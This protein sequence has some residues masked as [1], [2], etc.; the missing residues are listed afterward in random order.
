MVKRVARGVPEDKVS[1]LR[2]SY[3]STWSQFVIEI[4]KL[5]GM[6]YWRYVTSATLGGWR[7]NRFY[8]KYSV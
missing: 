8:R 2:R 3:E 4:T 7:L 6:R 1:P 5:S